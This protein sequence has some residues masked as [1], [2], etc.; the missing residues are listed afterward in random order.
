MGEG[1]EVV[2]NWAFLV[3]EPSLPAFRD[4]IHRANRDNAAIGLAFSLT[5]PWPP[6]SFA[7]AL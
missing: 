3:D 6:F 2:L 4:E 1:V 7:P 5:G